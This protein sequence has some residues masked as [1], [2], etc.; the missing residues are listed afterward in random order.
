LN[1]IK[2]PSYFY[3]DLFDFKLLWRVAWLLPLLP[4]S[5]WLGK[6]AAIRINKLTFDRIIIFFLAVSGVWLLVR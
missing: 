6:W 5:V 4:I 1:W 2:V 3:A